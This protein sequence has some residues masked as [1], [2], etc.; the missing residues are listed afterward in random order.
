MQLALLPV[1][2]DSAD[3]R[4]RAPP[5]HPSVVYSELCASHEVVTIELKHSFE[6]QPAS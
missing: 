5:S 4:G 1:N 2:G 6:T 3:L